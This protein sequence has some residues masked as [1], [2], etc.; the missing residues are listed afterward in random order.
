MAPSHFDNLGQLPPEII[1]EQ[2][3]KIRLLT[4]QIHLVTHE[5]NLLTHEK[6]LLTEKYHL[7]TDKYHLVTDEKNLLTEQTRRTTLTE[8][9]EACHHRLFEHLKT[10]T[11][12][13]FTTGG[14]IGNPEGKKRPDRMTPWIRFPQEQEAMLTHLFGEYPLSDPPKAFFSRHEIGGVG[15]F[16]GTDAVS[17]EVDLEIFLK[18]ALVTPVMMILNNFKTIES[19]RDTFKL[20]TIDFSFQNH[21]NIPPSETSDTIVVDPSPATPGRPVP[22]DRNRGKPDWVCFY[23]DIAGNCLGTI[24][25]LEYKPPHKLTLAHL[26]HGLREM[27]LR[28]V[29]E[30]DVIPTDDAARFEH[31]ADLMVAS[32][33]TQ[34]FNYM[35]ESGIEFGVLS[36]G[37]ALVFLHLDLKNPKTVYFHLTEPLLDVAAQKKQFPNESFIHLTAVS[38]LLAYVLRSL[39]PKLEGKKDG[40]RQ[41]LNRL[42]SETLS[43][44]KRNYQQQT[45][46]SAEP[47]TFTPRSDYKPTAYVLRKP[48]RS[49]SM[50]DYRKFFRGDG[51]NESDDENENDDLYQPDT[52]TPQ[53][54]ENAAYT[55]RGTRGRGSLQVRI[56]GGRQKRAYCTHA[57]LLGLARGLP[58]DPYCPNL[59]LHQTQGP[60]M[61]HHAISKESFPRLLREQLDRS[62]DIDCYPIGKHGARG[63][64]FKLTLTAYGYTVIGKGTMKMDSPCLRYERSV[65]DHL[66]SIQGTHIPVC[67]GHTNL[68]WPYAYDINIK[69]SDFLLLSFVGEDSL[70]DHNEG[71]YED[72]KALEQIHNAGVVHNDVRSPNILWSE[73]AT[74]LMLIDLERAEIVA[75]PK[76]PSRPRKHKTGTRTPVKDAPAKTEVACTVTSQMQTEVQVMRNI[77]AG[78][79]NWWTRTA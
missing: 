68:V 60:G 38:Q 14:G 51:G 8:F 34:A 9:L 40:D 77:L 74:G 30:R 24:L 33:V 20:D 11:R 1:L 19:L 7:L 46:D 59:N 70:Y 12:S 6:N 26:S 66:S 50:V 63:Y 3:E 76:K 64:M 27:D 65:Y 32:G 52:P 57:C 15:K 36:T 23:V 4:E 58:F 54:K 13:L 39:A 44:W 22:S 48:E 16:V 72:T 28:E 73:E 45:K 29:I 75:P 31:E 5:K 47:Y 55:G 49:N 41:K 18:P 67:L 69:I 25:V 53:R 42:A 2:E 10:E 62:L 21:K 61:T 35:V 78:M 79:Q 71:Q 17:S 56:S 43:T 37:E